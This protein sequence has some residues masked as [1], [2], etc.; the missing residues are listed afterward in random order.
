MDLPVKRRGTLADQSNAL[1]VLFF[2]MPASVDRDFRAFKV[3]ALPIN[4]LVQL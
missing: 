2:Y 1:S 3:T 4:K